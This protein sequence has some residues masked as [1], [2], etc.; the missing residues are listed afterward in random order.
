MDRIDPEVATDLKAALDMIHKAQD[1]LSPT[2]PLCKL[3]SWH[4]RLIYD[5]MDGVRRGDLK[6]DEEMFSKWFE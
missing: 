2:S 5:L 6:I 1:R 4:Y 3:L